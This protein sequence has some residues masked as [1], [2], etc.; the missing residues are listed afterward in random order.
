MNGDM[1]Q[2]LAEQVSAFHLPRYDELPDMGLYL[3][4][5][6]KYVNRYM[7][8]CA[9]RITPSMV[10]NYVKQRIIPGPK[11]K[12]YEKE[13]LACLIY[14]SFMKTVIP[15][16]QIRFMFLTQ[17][18]SYELKV[19]YDYFCDEFENLLHFAFGLKEK[20]DAVG[21]D[22]TDEKELLRSA[23]L[24]AAHRIYLE[25]YILLLREKT[26]E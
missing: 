17:Q 23:L 2:R 16:D 6:T 9:C 5:A 10:S 18:R 14:V 26:G 7:S 4:Q 3:D 1:K 15:L 11:G 21:H 24:S 12:T 8:L 19:A 25:Q 20:P 13:A 22:S